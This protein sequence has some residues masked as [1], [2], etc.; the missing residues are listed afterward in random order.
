[1]LLFLMLL[2]YALVQ[3][4]NTNSNLYKFIVLIILLMLANNVLIA[5]VIHS[6]KRYLFYFDWV[7]FAVIILFVNLISKKQL[8]EY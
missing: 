4:W 7:L 3:L 6:I 5:T 1:M 8:N 2:I